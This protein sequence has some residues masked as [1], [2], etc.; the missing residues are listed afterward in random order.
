MEEKNNNK[1]N[2]EMTTN[3]YLSLLQ[4]KYDCETVYCLM[5]LSHLISQTRKRYRQNQTLQQGRAKVA[6][7]EAEG[8]LVQIGLEVFFGQAMIGAQDKRFGVADHD[9]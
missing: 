7:A 9:V 8:K 6:A 3:D 5:W 2:A 1:Y 4:I